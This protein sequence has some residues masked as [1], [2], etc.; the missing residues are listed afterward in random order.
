MALGPWALLLAP[1]PLGYCPRALL[2]GP[3]WLRDSLKPGSTVLGYRSKVRGLIE[4]RPAAEPAC[5]QYAV[6]KVTIF[7]CP[8][9]DGAPVRQITRGTDA[10]QRLAQCQTFADLVDDLC[11][12]QGRA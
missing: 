12:A 6:C 3:S 11:P 8:A 5:G 1:A 4:H 10:A 2:A 7:D 9:V